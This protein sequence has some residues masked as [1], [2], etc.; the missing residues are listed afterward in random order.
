MECNTCQ[1][2]FFHK[3]P[4]DL[5]TAVFA[6]TVESVGTVFDHGNQVDHLCLKGNKHWIYTRQQ[7][8]DQMQWTKQYIN[9]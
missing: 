5:E 7:E 4:C 2:L 3:C 8:G 1:A 9:P 6:Q